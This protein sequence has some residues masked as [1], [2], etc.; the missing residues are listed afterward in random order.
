MQDLIVSFHPM[1]AADRTI[2][3]ESR[4][5][6]NRSDV[7]AVSRAEAVLMPLAPRPDVYALVAGL[8]KPMF[9][10]PAVYL[11]LD[12]KIGNQRLFNA[13][14]LPHP[15]AITFACVDDALK[16]WQDNSGE[17]LSLGTPLVAK[18]AGGGMGD[19]VFLVNTT[20]ELARVARRID[21][22]CQNGP[23]GLLLQ[24]FIDCGGTDL[25]V[26][27]LGDD[28]RAYWRH[29]AD[30]QWR[31]NLSQNGTADFDSRP[32][33]MAAGVALAR[34][35][36]D[37]AGLDMAGVDVLMPPG[38]RP[39]LLEINFFFGR[40]ALGGTDAFLQMHMAA[41]HRWLAGRGIDPERVSLSQD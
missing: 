4:R 29:G 35:L 38:E 28:H 13:L 6:L 34:R 18:G 12:G 10:N 24:Q 9:P 36:A 33:E 16:A 11:S 32:G 5:A 21:T 2:V 25:R 30:G 31:S 23:D 3:L 15:Q 19:N 20:D 1:I 22:R 26:V 41:V 40:S 27:I 7:L 37:A 39:L 14:G 17:L 8:G